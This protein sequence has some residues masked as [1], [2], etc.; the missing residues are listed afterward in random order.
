[1]NGLELMASGAHASE[2]AMASWACS[3]LTDPLTAR[4]LI[5]GL[6]FG[7]TLRATLDVLPPSASIVVAELIPE[8]VRW[9]RGP[10]AVL[11]GEPLSDPRVEVRVGDAADLLRTTQAGFDGVL[12]D[13]DNGPAAP[14]RPANSV[15]FRPKGLVAIRN[16]LRPG[17]ILAIW[18]ADPVGDFPK[19][20]QRA[21]FTAASRTFPAIDRPRSPRHTVYLGRR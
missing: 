14:V 16:A 12:L 5:G 15:L 10:I 11:A 17:G 8:V 9:V 18:S 2:E 7:Y 6:G 4:V 1:M 20:L 21:G 19:R 13:I 3:E